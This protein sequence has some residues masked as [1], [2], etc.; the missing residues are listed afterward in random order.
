[1]SQYALLHDRRWTAKVNRMMCDIRWYTFLQVS[2]L[3]LMKPLVPLTSV[4]L[5]QSLIFETKVLPYFMTSIKQWKSSLHPSNSFPTNK[6]N[7]IQKNANLYSLFFSRMFPFS[8]RWNQQ[9][10][11]F[12]NVSF[13]KQAKCCGNRFILLPLTRKKQRKPLPSFPTQLT[14]PPRSKRGVTRTPIFSRICI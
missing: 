1:M 4:I 2:L 10:F 8:S 13:F 5:T 9:F 14:P 12:P 11:L 6:R 7:V 3:T